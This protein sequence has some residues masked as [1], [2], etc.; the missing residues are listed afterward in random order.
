MEHGAWGMEWCA[1]LDS[2]NKKFLIFI[3]ILMLRPAFHI[4][5]RSSATGI[6][7]V[8]EGNRFD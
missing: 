2:A 3:K 6:S 4:L 7:S 8:P 1:D 5:V